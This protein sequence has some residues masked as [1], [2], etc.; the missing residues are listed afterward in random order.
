[1]PVLSCSGMTSSE[2]W[3]GQNDAFTIVVWDC[4]RTYVRMCVR[5]LC[6]CWCVGVL[7][8]CVQIQS[9]ATNHSLK[10]LIAT[11]MAKRSQFESGQVGAVR[12]VFYPRHYITLHCTAL[13]NAALHVLPCA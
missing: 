13:H 10:S 12:V 5:V 1:M 2:L 6:V 7:V 9:R 11:F 4:V 3:S 8:R